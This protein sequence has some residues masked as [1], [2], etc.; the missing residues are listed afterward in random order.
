[1]IAKK[2]IL[3]D[4][5][6][7]FRMLFTHALKIR[8]VEV[9]TFQSGHMALNYLKSGNAAPDCVFVDYTMP[10]MMGDEFIAE[11]RR[12]PKLNGIRVIMCSAH[13]GIE[14]AAKGM[15]A[16]GFLSKP[17]ELADLYRLVS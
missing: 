4:D 3:I 17:F 1:M 7:D 15:G 9:V 6:P 11:L 8:N 12:D 16:D 5:T 10:E 2:V 14:L 13:K